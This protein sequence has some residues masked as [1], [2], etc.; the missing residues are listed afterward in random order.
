MFMNFN[1]AMAMAGPAMAAAAPD[2]GAPEV[3]VRKNFPETFATV[4]LI[5]E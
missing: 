1:G 4:D 3:V 5:T 2:G